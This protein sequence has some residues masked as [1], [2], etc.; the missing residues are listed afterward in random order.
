MLISSINIDNNSLKIAYINTNTNNKYSCNKPPIFSDKSNDG[1]LATNYSTGYDITRKDSLLGSNGNSVLT[2]YNTLEDVNNLIKDVKLPDAFKNY[3]NWACK[4]CN[5]KNI[6]VLGK[7]KDQAQC[8]SCWDF[9]TTC[10]LESKIVMDQ[11]DNNIPYDKI[12]V[13][14]AE[15]YVL[16]KSN[17]NSGCNGGLFD[18][19]ITD[20]EKIG[21]IPTEVCSYQATAKSCNKINSEDYIIPKNDNEL[22]ATVLNLWDREINIQLTNNDVKTLLFKYGPLVTAIDA[23]PLESITGNTIAEPKLFSVNNSPDHQVVL[24]GY[25]I[26]KEKTPYWII[27]NSWG[28][29]W[30]NNGFGAIKMND[31]NPG[32]IFS[33]LGFITKLIYNYNSNT[34]KYYTNTTNYDLN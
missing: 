17:S 10:G 8:G 11:I 13:S 18:Y 21:D 3:L 7:I 4:D 25:G 2:S 1:I 32:D 9:G 19:A 28:E 30:S 26:S 5:P 22:K 12:Y 24:I 31:D 29:S 14:L 15:Q 34:K 6:S 16:D 33:E 20:I 23:S 27:R